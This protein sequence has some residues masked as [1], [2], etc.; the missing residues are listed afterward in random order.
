[1][2]SRSASSFEFGRS[3]T[4]SQLQPKSGLVVS[5]TQ[6]QNSLLRSDAFVITGSVME[7]ERQDGLIGHRW[8]HYRVERR[9]A[10]GGMGTLYLLV[11]EKYPESKLVMK[12]INPHVTNISDIQARFEQEARVAA[13]IGQGRVP[14]L[15]DFDFLPDG[16]P[17]IA[18]EYVPGRSLAEELACS[19]PMRLL[20][21]L[22]IVKSVAETVA[23]AQSLGV[24]HRDLKPS[25]IML[26]RTSDQDFAVKLLD[27]GIAQ[28]TGE[29]QL[30]QTAQAVAIGTRGYM[31]PE[32]LAASEV[33]GSTDVYSLGTVL[34]ETLTGQLP[35]P[36]PNDAESM[37]FFFTTPP[38]PLAEVRP[39][40]LDP[41]P[42][43]LE[44]F[45]YR[46]LARQPTERPSISEFSNQLRRAIQGLS[47]EADYARWRSNDSDIVSSREMQDGLPAIEMSEASPQPGGTV[48][49]VSSWS[50]Q[51][52]PSD[53]IRAGVMAKRRLRRWGG[54]GLLA[55]ILCG[56]ALSGVGV[57]MSLV[58]AKPQQASKQVGTST[59]TDNNLGTGGVTGMS[60][61]LVPVARERPGP[62]RPPL[63]LGVADPP[64]KV[65]G[66][67]T[68]NRPISTL[69]K[70]HTK[71]AKRV[72]IRLG[73]TK[74]KV[75]DVGVLSCP[76]N[77]KM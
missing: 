61:P 22:Q 23:I 65:A 8:H 13:A 60:V 63:S 15:Y 58:K 69:D 30:V 9:L 38:R 20:P 77:S 41:V 34:Y 45:I 73:G 11:H 76:P 19:G 75:V 62:A 40:Q 25:N 21:A 74:C 37:L 47:L 53:P 56:V 57:S 71:S 48:A 42:V 43:W 12:V 32:A 51:G 49:A 31:S 55:L 54:L 4:T 10:E 3:A 1:M 27:F 14:Q 44:R 29:L 72:G 7:H 59:P 24:I 67:N 46:A 35:W 6:D 28:V 26:M 52:D 36:P 2:W 39:V 5:T 68:R 50:S 64:S 18:M 17:F 66:M 33:D 70:E 16:R